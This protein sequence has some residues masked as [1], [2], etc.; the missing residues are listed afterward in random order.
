MYMFFNRQAESHASKVTRDQHNMH[1][2]KTI[3]YYRT[4]NNHS[5]VD[6]TTPFLSAGYIASPASGREIVMQYAHPGEGSGL[7]Y[8]TKH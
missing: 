5:I 7:V 2:H 4:I 6:Q 1:Y 8:E 3:N